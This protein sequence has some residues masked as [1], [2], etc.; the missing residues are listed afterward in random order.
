[1]KI[2]AIESTAHTLG[3]SIVYT[4]NNKIKI[5]NN[6]VFRYENKGGYVPRELAEHH[7]KFFK[8]AVEMALRSSKTKIKEIDAVAYSSSPGI[9]HALHVGW[10]GAKAISLK[11]DIPLIGVNHAKAHIEIGKYFCRPTDALYVFISG[12]NT[13]LVV[14][15]GKR[16]KILGETLDIG[17]GNFLDRVGRTLKLT[18]PNAVGVINAYKKSQKFIELPYRVKGANVAFAGLLTAVEK[19]S[20]KYKK[21]DLA[22]SAQETAASE[23]CE[24][25][26]K[27]LAHLKKKEIIAVG[28]NAQ[29]KRIREMLS[30]VAKDHKAE[31]CAPPAQYCGDNAAMIGILGIKQFLSKNYGLQ[32]PKQKA[33]VDES[34]VE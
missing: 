11:Y 19:L 30:A 24:V 1:M 25:T 4:K 29:N 15:E 26:E 12:G 23:L 9:G 13:Q 7:A 31:F 21:E 27:V 28:G 2:L 34:E 14:E 33:R 8:E 17:I 18:P 20:H 22:Y 10:V 32:E 16:Y 6:V 3:A 5:S